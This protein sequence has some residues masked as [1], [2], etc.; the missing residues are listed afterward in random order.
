MPQSIDRPRPSLTDDIG[1]NLIRRGANF[2]IWRPSLLATGEVTEG[3]F[4]D[5]LTIFSVFP[6]VQ[7]ETSL[8]DHRLLDRFAPTVLPPEYGIYYSKPQVVETYSGE[9]LSLPRYKLPEYPRMGEVVNKNL[10]DSRLQKSGVGSFNIQRG[11]LLVVY[12]DYRLI[13]LHDRSVELRQK[14]Q[15]GYNHSILMPLDWWVAHEDI[16]NWLTTHRG[17]PEANYFKEQSLLRRA[18]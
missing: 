9:G 12:P 1:K 8:R 11:V 15:P 18:S 6:R 4:N 13:N 3:W 17:L 5:G 16:L 7:L 14:G 2:T 10:L